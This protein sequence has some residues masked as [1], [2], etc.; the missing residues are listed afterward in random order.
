MVS[1]METDESTLKQ[2]YDDAIFLFKGKYKNVSLKNGAFDTKML[3]ETVL[4]INVVC[5]PLFETKDAPKLNVDKVSDSIDKMSGSF[6]IRSDSVEKIV[7]S[8]LAKTKDIFFKL[9]DKDDANIS[10]SDKTET[11][12]KGED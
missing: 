9:L 7:D 4:G 11:S 5:M 10:A 2:N 6:D 1:V 8:V 3:I 12:K